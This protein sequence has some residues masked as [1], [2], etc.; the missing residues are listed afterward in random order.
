MYTF[1]FRILFVFVFFKFWYWFF[2]IFW[3]TARRFQRFY[4]FIFSSRLQSLANIDEVVARIRMR[5]RKLDDEIRGSIRSQTDSESNGK[6]VSYI[7]IFFKSN[8]ELSTIINR[9]ARVVLII[10]MGLTVP[11]GLSTILKHLC[12]SNKSKIITFTSFKIFV[13][14]FLLHYYSLLYHKSFV[15]LGSRSCQSRYSRS[16]FKD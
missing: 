1:Q 11:I 12:N 6:Q 10:K 8:S 7:I 2:L 15:D 4:T 9:L 16:L 5:I 13:L 3:I 14:L